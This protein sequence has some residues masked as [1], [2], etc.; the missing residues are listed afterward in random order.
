MRI[1]RGFAAE[2][3]PLIATGRR[4]AHQDRRGAGSVVSGYNLVGTL[5][6]LKQFELERP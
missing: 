6:S 5:K 3:S 2:P 1:S 4:G